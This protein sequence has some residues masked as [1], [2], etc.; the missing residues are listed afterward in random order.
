MYWSA[1]LCIAEL[2]LLGL[3][4]EKHIKKLLVVCGS[5]LLLLQI[6]ADWQ[7]DASCGKTGRGDVMFRGY[8]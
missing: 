2:H 8:K 6:P 7:S 4:R 1:L 3:H 5:F